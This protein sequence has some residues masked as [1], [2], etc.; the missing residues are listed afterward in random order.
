M[1]ATA[2]SRADLMLSLLQDDLSKPQS[3]AAL[4]AM[5][6]QALRK[7]ALKSRSTEVQRQ[8]ALARE[9]RAWTRAAQCGDFGENVDGRCDF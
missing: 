3:A 4:K 6:N 7:S 5:Q 1:I 9:I 8:S 2:V